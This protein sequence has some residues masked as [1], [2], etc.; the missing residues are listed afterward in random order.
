LDFILEFIAGI[1]QE[2]L[3]MLLKFFGAIIRWCIFLGNKKFKDV[4]NEEWNT[5]VGL[6]TLIIIIIAIFNLG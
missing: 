6:F 1:F 4:L 2:A 5:R 3:P